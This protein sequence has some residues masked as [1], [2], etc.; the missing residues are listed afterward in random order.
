MIKR[1][2]EGAMPVIPDMVNYVVD[3]RDCAR[4]HIAVMND[5]STN[6]HRHFSFSAVCKIADWAQMIRDRYE[7]I[8]LTPKAWVVPTSLVWLLQPFSRDLAAVYSKLGHSNAYETKWP[9]VYRYVHTDLSGIVESSI[10]SVLEHGWIKSEQTRKT[11][12]RRYSGL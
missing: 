11:Q 2:A 8:G 1:V 7:K 3:V 9:E 12:R 10:D 6:G 5:P 4:M